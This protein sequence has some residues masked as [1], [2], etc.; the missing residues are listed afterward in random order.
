M[1]DNRDDNDIFTR[2]L[3][4]ARKRTLRHLMCALERQAQQ[5]A[6]QARQRAEN[7]RGGRRP[8]PFNP[9]TQL[10]REIMPVI[11]QLVELAAGDGPP[12]L[13]QQ[14]GKKTAKKG[15]AAGRRR[16]SASEESGS[17]I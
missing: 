6:I 1:T 11:T 2:R 7:A 12:L 3:L 5:Q 9:V 17:A 16:R 13:P 8:K 4:A 10:R 15:A 14:P